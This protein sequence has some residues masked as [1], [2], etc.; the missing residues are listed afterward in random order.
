MEGSYLTNKPGNMTKCEF[1][2]GKLWTYLLLKKIIWLD[3][4]NTLP[5]RDNLYITTSSR[6]GELIFFQGSKMSAAALRFIAMG[7]KLM[8]RSAE[9]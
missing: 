7:Y 4:F 1:T 2:R 6:S 3:V 5:Y 9:L 8:I